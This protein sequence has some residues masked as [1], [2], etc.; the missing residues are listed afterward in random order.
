[1]QNQAYFDFSRINFNQLVRLLA[2]PRYRQLLLENAAVVFLRLNQHRMKTEAGRKSS[3]P[4]E[5][6]DK[7]KTRMIHKGDYESYAF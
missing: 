4:V 7:V 6:P 5:I 2:N 3:L 1:M